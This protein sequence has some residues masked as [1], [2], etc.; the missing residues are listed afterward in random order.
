MQI[1]KVDRRETTY[2]SSLANDLVYNQNKLSQFIQQPFDKNNF[3]NQIQEKAKNYDNS[4][5]VKL[6]DCLVKQH[7]DFS[8]YKSVNTNIELLSKENAFTVTSGHQLSLYSGPLYVIYKIMNTIK[9]A[10]ELKKE[11]PNNHFIPVFW[12]ASEDHDF[13]EINHINLFNDSLKWESNQKGPVGRF[14]L[15]DFHEFKDK[16]L[17]KFD[18]NKEFAAYLNQFYTPGDECLSVAT[19]RF[20]LN[21]FGDKG[22]VIIDADERSLKSL[23]R[24]VFKK[25]LKSGFSSKAVEST[26]KSL[27]D[28]GYKAQVAAREINLFYIENQRRDRII[29]NADDTFSIGEEIFSENDLLNILEKFPERF[30]PNVVLRPVFQEWILPNLCYLGGGGEM[31]YWLQLKGVFNELNL[32]YP[33]INVRNSIQWFD[34]I[35]LKKINK[36]ELEVKQLFDS[37]HENQKKFVLD[38]SDD[39][40][41]FS[42]I[43]SVGEEL[44]AKMEN[45]IGAVDKGLEG[46]AK[47]ESVKI[48]KQME[49]LKQ[50]LIRH[51]KKLHEDSMQQIENLYERLFPNNGLQERYENIIPIL[52][53][54]GK[55]KT[56]EMIYS[57]INPFEK[58]LILLLDL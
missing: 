44:K 15:D 22:L 2:F 46:Y 3:K 36:L 53:N 4:F 9:L 37:I 6:S 30:S 45:L 32:I 49:Q 23:F 24:P 29:K 28:K 54:N 52:A 57:A 25:E 11:H 56:L 39:E 27:T 12:M 47:S 31:A 50:K 35:A 40:L 10:D 13:E 18:N 16:L 8:N 43:E 48:N 34:K 42:E 55:D 51:Q 20:L 26:T 17:E 21:L 38:H 19:R 1:D 33:L 58:D 41:D 5:R 7:A 14:T